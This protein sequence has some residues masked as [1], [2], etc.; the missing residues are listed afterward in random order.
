MNQ[1]QMDA[2][3]DNVV[4]RFKGDHRV[5]I[6]RDRSADFFARVTQHLDWVYIDGDH[7]LEAVLNDLRSAWRCVRPRGILCGDDLDW[8][9]ADGTRPV[10]A[11]LA[12][13]AKETATSYSTI[14]NQ[15]F[16][17]RQD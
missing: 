10:L 1:H 14:G 11:A 4:K 2:I 3:F 13:F 7:S 5:K 15:F 8:P 16:I 17:Q 6:H 12:I 9:D